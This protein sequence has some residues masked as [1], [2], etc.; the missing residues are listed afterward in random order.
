MYILTDDQDIKLGS[1]DVQPVVKSLLAEQGLFFSNAFVTTPVCCPSRL[2][3]ITNNLYYYVRM[4]P[5]IFMGNIHRKKSSV[6]VIPKSRGQASF[7][8]SP[9]LRGLGSSAVER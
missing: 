8:F 4:L 9:P 5:L 7:P 1:L 2:T 6:M 3:V